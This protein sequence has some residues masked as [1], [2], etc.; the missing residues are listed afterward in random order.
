MGGIK[1]GA[2]AHG[3]KTTPCRLAG[4]FTRFAYPLTRTARRLAERR[5]LRIVTVGSSSTA[6]A[7]ATSQAATYPSRLSAELANYFPNSIITVFNRGVNGEQ[8]ADMV[9]RFDRT[10]LVEKP[11]LVL[12]Q[13]GTNSL[14]MNHPL[15]PSGSLINEGVAKLKASGADVVLI[16]PQFAPKVLKKRDAEGMVALIAAAAKLANVDL[17]RRFALMRRWHETEGLPFSTFLSADELHMND[18]SYQ[19]VARHIAGAIAEAVNRPTET[20]SFSSPF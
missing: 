1:S 7:G 5:P 8:A 13:V 19:C 10:V 4:E 6:G 2:T 14:L 3:G 17:F 18:W 11:D 16:D 12:W 15:K 20:A 9:K